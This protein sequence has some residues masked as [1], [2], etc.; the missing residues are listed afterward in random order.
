[1]ARPGAKRKSSIGIS[2]ALDQP[3]INDPQIPQIFTDYF[4][5]QTSICAFQICV[6]L[7]NL[8]TKFLC[9]TRRRL[10]VQSSFRIRAARKRIA[11]TILRTPSA[12]QSDP[13]SPI[14]G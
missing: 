8:W 3:R 11:S 9:P 1:M 12:T 14:S 4:L 2:P 5:Q 7:R 13:T 10:S 6:N